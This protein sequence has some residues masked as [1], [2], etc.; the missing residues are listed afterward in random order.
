MASLTE[1]QSRNLLLSLKALSDETRIRILHILSL[2]TFSVNEVTEILVMGQSRISRHLKI[3]ADAGL[4]ESSREGSWVYYK[5]PEIH[6]FGFQDEII[7]LLISWKEYLP[8]ME[9]DQNKVSRLLSLREEKRNHYFDRVGNELESVQKEVLHP[10]IYREKLVSLLPLNSETIL[11]A[12]CG[13]GQFVPYLL[14]RTKNVIGVDSSSKMIEIAGKNF[15]RNKNVSFQV[16]SLEALPLAD[17]SIDAIVTSMVLHHISNPP[18]VLKEFHRILKPDGTICIVDLEK[19]DEEFMRNNYADLWLG[20]DKSLLSEW[21]NLSGF[22][23]EDI[24][25]MPANSAPFATGNIEEEF[26]NTSAVAHQMKSLKYDHRVIQTRFKILII[27]AKRR[28][29]VHSY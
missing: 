6:A 7:K 27:K 21:L 22:V 11:D 13:T 12:G 8:Q 20:F 28:T 15:A 10:E 17:E 26:S 3:L 23:I 4:I 25:V 19:H 9:Y 5:I 16:S 24:E 18:L 14:S 1:N 29:Y 2:G